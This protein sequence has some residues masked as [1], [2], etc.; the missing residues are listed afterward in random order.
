MYEDALAHAKAGAG[1]KGFP[2][3]PAHERQARGLDMRQVAG[4]A[5]DEIDVR[6][7]DLA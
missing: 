2:D 5:A 6:D 3:G 7:V 1:D 4:L